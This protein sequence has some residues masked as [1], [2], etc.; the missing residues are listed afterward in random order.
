MF[1]F[2]R[3]GG[4]RRQPA[5]MLQYSSVHIAHVYQNGQ[6]TA[7]GVVVAVVLMLLM[8]AANWFGVLLFARVNLAVTIARFMVPTVTL[9]GLL[10]QPQPLPAGLVRARRRP[11]RGAARLPARFRLRGPAAQS[12]AV[13]S[14]RRADRRQPSAG[15]LTG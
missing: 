8:I 2:K 13:R 9:G 4:A 5:A 12:V 11:L 14:V 10:A 6:L 15:G 1:G 3:D 7:L